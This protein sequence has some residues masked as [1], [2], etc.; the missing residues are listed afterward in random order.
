MAAR[1]VI[2]GTSLEPDVPVALFQTR[3]LLGGSEAPNG[4]EYDVAPDGRFLI[5]TVDDRSTAAITIVQHWR[6]LSE[7]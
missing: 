6:G 4:G 1:V 7:R 3:I 2:K 5:N